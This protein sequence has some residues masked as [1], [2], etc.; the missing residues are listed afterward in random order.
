MTNPNRVARLPEPTFCDMACFKP[1]GHD[2]P[3]QKWLG[4][5]CDREGCDGRCS[6]KVG[7]EYLCASCAGPPPEPPLSREQRL[8]ATLDD[9]LVALKM[10]FDVEGPALDELHFTDHGDNLNAAIVHAHREL[11]SDG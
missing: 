1:R 7:D 3:H 4:D 11:D 9:L 5:P 8:E 6:V 2:G 10:Y